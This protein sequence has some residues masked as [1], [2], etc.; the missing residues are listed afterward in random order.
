[1][2]TNISTLEMTHDQWLKRRFESIGA[3]ESGAIL[4]INP[5]KT[6]V[7]VYYE[8]VDKVTDF[9]DNLNMW[10]GRELEP[11]IK[12][13]F[14]EETGFKVRNDHKIRVDKEHSFLTTNLDGMVV[15]EKV[16]VEYKALGKWDGEIPNYYFSQIQHQMMVSESD[17]SY[18]VVLVLSSQKSF[19]IQKINRD[20]EFID[21]M[22]DEEVSFWEDHVI[23]HD[24]PAPE[25]I[26]DARKIYTDSVQGSKFETNHPNILN[27]INLLAE[28]KDEIKQKKAV[29]DNIQKELMETMQEDE[30]IVNKDTGHVLCSWKQSAD[31]LRFDAKRFKEENPD[32]YAKYMKQTTGTRRFLIK[33]GHN[34]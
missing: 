13:R 11:V 32:T 6:A 17:Y 30:L 22:R 19:I 31:S 33:G 24:P 29:C 23:P 34:G 3:S 27:K 12:K 18:F 21:L 16:P 9:P 2:I 26:E 20:N 28:T 8:K 4:G 15:G 10:L 7:D 1:M 25:T 14:E 5:W